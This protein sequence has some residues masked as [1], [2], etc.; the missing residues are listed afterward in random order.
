MANNN[1]KTKFHLVFTKENYLI[2]GVGLLLL[3]IGYLLLV[4]GGSK[5]PN[6]FSEDLFNTRRMVIAPI[7]MVLG[8]A[9]EIYAIMHTPRKKNKQEEEA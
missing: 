8:I 7:L 3:V 6:V 9:V 4:G 5:D 2:M 1:T